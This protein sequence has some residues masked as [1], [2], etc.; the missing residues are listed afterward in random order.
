MPTGAAA[1][2]TDISTVLAEVPDRVNCTRLLPDKRTVRFV[3]GTP[4]RAEDVDT[5]TGTRVPSPLVP[6]AYAEGCPDLSADGKRLVFQGHAKDG[7]AFAF[8]SDHPD[9]REAVPVVPN[10]EPSMDSEPT[11]L[12]DGRTFS[13][14]VDAKHM[15]V[16][17]T[18]VRADDRPSRTDGEAVRHLVQVCERRPG[19]RLDHFRDGRRRNSRKFSSRRSTKADGSGFAP[20]PVDVRAVG[21]LFYYSDV[22]PGRRAGSSSLNLPSTDHAVWG[23]CAT[24]SSGTRSS[25]LTGWF[26]LA[27]SSGRAWWW[28]GRGP[29]TSSLQRRTRSAPPHVAVTASSSRSNTGERVVIERLNAEGRLV[30]EP[31]RTVRWDTSPALLAR[32]QGRVLPSQTARARRWRGAMRRGVAASSTSTASNPTVSP[33]GRRIA[34]WC[35]TGDK[36]GPLVKVADADGGRLRELME[37]ETAASRDGRRTTRIWV[38]R[39]RGARI[40]WTE[41]EVDS[42]RETGRSVQGSRDCADGRPDPQSRCART[43]A[44]CTNRPSELRLLGKQALARQQSTSLGKP[45]ETR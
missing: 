5:V 23:G 1:D 13:F 8:L 4:P 14:D 41:V 44:S 22:S 43:C 38:S 3:W 18:V 39:R 10:A 21:P 15:G 7:R 42:G 34:I 11:W 30:A 40:L 37:T 12:A 32:R 20:T 45:D 29:T 24:A 25:R 2:W 27:C 6:A 33:D 26:S 35:T 19:R 17:S 16:F 28:R 36:R 31:S 9:G